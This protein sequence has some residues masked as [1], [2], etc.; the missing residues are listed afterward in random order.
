MAKKTWNIPVK[1]LRTIKAPYGL[2]RVK[3]IRTK[4]MEIRHDKRMSLGLQ[5]FMIL[6]DRSD[7]MTLPMYPLVPRN[8]KSALFI[9]NSFFM[10][11]DPAGKIPVSMF[12]HRFTKN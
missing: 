1:I 4:I 7:P 10:I 11:L 9:F 6:V 3:R 5:V 2:V 12:T 8:P